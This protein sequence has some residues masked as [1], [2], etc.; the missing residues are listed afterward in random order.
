MYGQ[1]NYAPPFGQGPQK[2]WPPAYQQRAVAPPPPTSYGQPGPTIPSRPITQQTPAPPPQAAQSLHLSQPGSHGPPPPHCQG[3]SIQVR[4]GGITNIRPAYFHTFPPVHGSTQVSLFNSSAQQNVQLSHSGVQ[5]MH[6]VLPPPPPPLPPPPLPPHAPNSNL[7]RPPQPSTVGPLHAPHAHARI[8]PPLPPPHAR[9]HPPLQQGGLQVFPSIPQLPTTS[10]FP[11]PSSFGGVM[12]SNLGR[13]HLL[14]M[15]PPPPPSS[16]PPI[17]PSPP[18]P[19]SSSSSIPDPDSSNLSCRSEL[20]PSSTVH[21]GKDLEPSEIDQGCAPPSHLG[22]NVPMHDELRNSQVGNGLMMVSNVDNEI[23]SDKNFVK[24]LPPPPPKPKDDRIV[25]KIEVLCKFIANNGSIFEDTT[26]QKEFGNPEFGFLFGGEPGSESAVGHEYFQWMK[27][28]YSLASKNIAMKEKSPLRSS[29]IEPQSEN[30]TVS[31]ASISPV[32]SDM[33]MEDDITIADIGEETSHSFP[34]QSYECKS[35]KE[36]HDAKDQLQE[37]DVFR[38]CSLEKEK[39]AE[40]GGPKLLLDHEKSVSIAACQVHSHV[41]STAGVTEQPPGGSPFRLIQDYASDENSE[42]DEEP[43]H[44]DV[45]FVATSSSTPAYSK[46]S[47]K[48]TD[49][50]TI[51]GSKGSCQV[52]RAQFLSESPKQVFDAKEANV[53][54]TGNEQ[55]Y[56]N[57]QNQIGSGSG[58]KSLN[59][60]NG[61]SIDVPQDTD[62][63]QKENDAEHKKLGSSPVK[64]DEFGRLVR[65]GDS[66]SDSDDSHYTRRH[67]NRRARNSSESRSPVDRRRGRRS[68]R[69]RRERRSRSRSWSPR[70]HR[71]RSRSPVIRRSSQF[72]H[73]NMRRDKGMIGK[74]FDFQRGRCYRGA[75]CRYEHHEPHK[76][77]GSRFHRSKHLDDH[78]TSKNIKIR[79]DTMNMSREVS[80]LGYIKI[81]SQECI[82]HNES[83]KGNTHEWKTDRPTG[84]PDSFVTKCQSSR[85][86]IG[87]IQE[88]LIYS[89]PVEAVHIH[90][91]DNVQEAEKSYEQCS[92]TTSAAEKF[93]DDISTSMLTSVENSVA[94]QSSMFVAELQTANDLSHQMDGSSVSNLL[95]DQVTAVNANKAPECEHGL[96][97]TSSIKPHFGTSSASQLPLTSQILSQSPVPKPLSA[98]APVCAIDDAHLLRELPPPPPLIISRVAST[99]VPV[100]AP[101]NFVLQNVSFPSK[102]SLPGGFHP[103]QDLVSI[104]PSHYHSTSLLPPKPL[105]DS[106]LTPVTTK[107]GMPMQFH[108]SHLSQGSDLGSQSIKKSQPLELHSHSKLGESPVQEPYRAPMHMDEVRSIAPVANNQPSQP[109]G[110]PSFQNEENFGRTSVETNSSSFFPHRNFND[111]SVPFTNANIMQSSGDNF[112]PSEFR[113]SFS[114][115]HPY[116]RFQQ[117]LYTSQPA[118]DS[119]FREPSQIGSMFQNYPDPLSRNHSSLLPDLGGLG[120]T[121][122]HNPYASTFEK[123]LSSSFRSNILNF[124]NDAPSGDIRSSTFNVS[125]VH[126]DGQGANYVGTRQTTASPNSTKPLGK[127]LLSTGGDQYDPLFDSIEPSLPI[128]KKSDCGQKLEKE[129]ES[130]TMTSLGSSHKLLYVEEN[131][132]HTEVAAVASTTTLENDE[133]G[134]T[135]DAEAGAVEDDLDDE[136]NL[137]GEIEIDQVKSSEKSKKSKGSRSLKLFRIAIADFVKEILKPSWRQGNMS[138]EAFKTI[139]KKT[140]DK[141][142]GAMKSHQIPKSQA[143]INRYIDSSQRK[144]TKLVMGYVDKYVKA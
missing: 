56:N 39:V 18:P 47:N 135:A 54:K 93:P 140:V 51:L 52:Q 23:L 5:N 60:M 88:E 9:I 4:P 116:S 111:H 12:Q 138:K 75:S 36:E 68:P 17:P 115:L 7:L 58:S 84:D 128:S 15:A 48:D 29:R 43:H 137:S 20:D 65:E 110:F 63:L 105:Y 80:D 50:L 122:Y 72:R 91:N 94:Q 16:P 57:Q 103:H 113:S 127:V 28:K 130:Y 121:S 126:V 107:D 26:R 59:A 64:I 117:P 83:P 104:Q 24:V 67:K 131:N 45:H 139:V 144:L 123:P 40:D 73:E 100:P 78:P 53:R 1:A 3:P 69:R 106:T 41:R 81:E 82:P 95:P 136:E 125:N 76:N 120:I 38:S 70:N 2:P 133:F 34:I 14:A 66:D 89:V 96:D 134:E 86:R 77:D 119:L 87:I 44:K 143:K 62:K 33:E 142:S 13:S 30:L 31:A 85:D 129:R 118:H 99:E 112:P 55:S 79:E 90:V 74:C 35:R 46:T 109:F 124:G 92:V 6:H 42:S 97:R 108:Q 98:T 22:D 114:Q 102:S 49:N 32:N 11:T 25:K 21:Y 27:K 101:Y 19:T 132:K 10:N 37:P 71:G 61:R 8:H 141:V